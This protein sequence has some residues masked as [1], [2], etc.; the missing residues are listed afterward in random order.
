M[1]FIYELNP[2]LVQI[3]WIYICKK[4]KK[5]YV[6]G[7]ESYR[8]TDRYTYIQTDRQICPRN[9]LP[10]RFAGGQLTLN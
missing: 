1:T 5:L 8:L 3:Y 6:K 4:T 9:Y 10:R 7:F 2:Y